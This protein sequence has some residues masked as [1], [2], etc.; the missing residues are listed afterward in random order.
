VPTAVLEVERHLDGIRLSSSIGCLLF[1]CCQ[2]SIF[3][4]QG[5]Q[6]MLPY[7]T[8]ASLHWYLAANWRQW[9]RWRGVANYAIEVSCVQSVAVLPWV[10][11]AEDC[12]V[13]SS[14]SSE[15]RVVEV[16]TV[17]LALCGCCPASVQSTHFR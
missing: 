10:D 16:C 17:G 4:A 15:G 5:A 1:F 3:T 11:I 2:G 13:G 9:P 14:G 12:N 7:M 8:V 6:L